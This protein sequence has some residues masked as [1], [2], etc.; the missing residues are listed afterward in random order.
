MPKS[1]RFTKDQ[2]LVA[3]YEARKHV[4]DYTSHKITCARLRAEVLG[5]KELP[6]CTCGYFDAMRKWQETLKGWWQGG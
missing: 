6:E 2:V 1:V 3:L 4:N 5:Q